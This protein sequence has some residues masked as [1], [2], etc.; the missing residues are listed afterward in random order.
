[1]VFVWSAVFASVLPNVGGV[2][3]GI[4]TRKNI[5]NWYEVS[6]K[7]TALAFQ[8]KNLVVVIAMQLVTLYAGYGAAIVPGF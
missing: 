4:V 8:G 7:P 1:M 3:G 2:A 5:P 6:F